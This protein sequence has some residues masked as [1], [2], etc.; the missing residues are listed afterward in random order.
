MS[1]HTVFDPTRNTLDAAASPYL[2]SHADNPVHWQEWSA[3]ACSYALEHSRILMVSVGYSTCHWCHVMAREAFSDPGIASYLNEHFVCIKVDREERPDIDSYMMNFML[4]TRGQGGWPLNVFLSPRQEP[5]FAMTYAPVEDRDGMPGFLS[6]LGRVTGFYRDNAA[7]VGPFDPAGEAEAGPV[8]I[9]GLHADLTDRTLGSYEFGP[10]LESLQKSFD[11]GT[12]GFGNGPRF[13][14]HSTLLW[15]LYSRD[16]LAHLQNDSTSEASAIDRI[17]IR[18]LD[19][20][21]Q[22]GLH[23]HLGGGFFRYCVD[24]AWTIPHFEKMLYD[25]ALLLWVYATAA[26]LYGRDDYAQTAHGIAACLERDFLKEGLFVSAHDADTGHRE[27]ET[28]LWSR[29]QIQEVLSAGEWEAFSRA[30]ELPEEGNFEGRIHLLRSDRYE[31]SELLQQAER[32]LLE[33]RQTREQPFVDEKHITHWN[34]LAGLGFAYA[35]RYLQHPAYEQRARSIADLIAGRHT[36]GDDLVHAVIDG[37]ASRTGFLD[38][39]ASFGL[40]LTVLEEIEPRYGELRRRIIDATASFQRDGQWYGSAQDDFRPVPAE[41]FDQ[42][43]PSGLSMAD[44]AFARAAILDRKMHDEGR[45]GPPLYEDFRNLGALLRAGL[46]H[47]VEGP[48]APDWSSLPVAT[49][50]VHASETRHCFAGACRTGPP[51]TVL[52]LGQKDNNI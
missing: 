44:M 24:E 2:R 22:R 10:A 49:V 23:D 50:F 35:G 46:W 13:P 28:Y 41:R 14:A 17:A 27:G 38:D 42:P 31:T 45:S 34:A 15:L 5:F 51:E 52:P 16:A 4:A 39:Y 21:Q 20:M 30:Y 37:T 19:V 36:A 47:I 26:R 40:L 48:D 29:E 32:S 33:A 3:E 9:S 43:V 18:L 12:A 7:K 8:S 25:Q 1:D 11:P 6:I